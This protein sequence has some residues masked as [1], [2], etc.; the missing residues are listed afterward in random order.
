MAA[1]GM[2]VVVMSAIVVVMSVMSVM[3]TATMLLEPV[4]LMIS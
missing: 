1:G 4:S 2:V 3:S